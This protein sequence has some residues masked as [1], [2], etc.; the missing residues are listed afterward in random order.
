MRIAKKAKTAPTKWHDVDLESQLHPE[1]TPDTP[2]GIIPEY[3]RGP[4]SELKGDVHYCLQM[5]IVLAGEAEVVCGN[6]RRTYRAN[7]LWWTMCW[8]PHAFKMLAK[9]NLILTVN[10]NI[11]SLVNLGPGVAEVDYLAPFTAPPEARFCPRTEQEH[12]E[13]GKLFRT[14]FRLNSRREKCW[15]TRC[16]LIIHQI[17]LEAAERMGQN[18]AGMTAVRSSMERIEHAVYLVRTQP[19]PPSL[20]QAATACNLSVSRFSAL[21]AAAMGT[22]YG[23]FSLRVRLAKAATDLKNG[24]ITLSALAEKYGFCD[25]SSLSNAFRRLYGCTPLEF[26][27]R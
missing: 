23:Q 14:L 5:S 13:M 19:V 27:H 25:A 20:P 6:F 1:L 8:E 21:F 18:A 9:R 17:L 22:S 15:K 11:D 7:E 10:L 2:F 24:T 4:Q 26:K 12:R 3:W 16:W